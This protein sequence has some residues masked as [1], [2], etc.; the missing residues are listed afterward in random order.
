MGKLPPFLTPK[1]VEN[2][3]GITRQTVN[4]AIF[5][6][7]LKAVKR[8]IHWYIMLKDFEAYLRNVG[9]V[10]DIENYKK[11]LEKNSDS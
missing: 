3:R 9:T 10:K 7:S 2:I 5:S 11:W 1:D 8:G 6:G 4:E